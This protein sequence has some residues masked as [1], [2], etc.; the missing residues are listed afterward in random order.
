MIYTGM[1]PPWNRTGRFKT[2]IILENIL[3]EESRIAMHHA[4]Y[5]PKFHGFK[6][7]ENMIIAERQL[8]DIAGTLFNLSGIIGSEIWSN[9]NNTV[10]HWHLDKDERH[11]DATGEI[12][13]PMCSI[14]YYPYIKDLE[15]GRLHLYEDSS[16]IIK[17]KQNMIVV[18]PSYIPHFVE[19]FTGERLSVISCPYAYNALP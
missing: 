6:Y 4:Y 19:P 14:V 12:K 11:Y 3:S 1:A 17:P 5:G 7:I 9:V 2:M 10:P 8:L 15:G 18:F 16:I 13:Y